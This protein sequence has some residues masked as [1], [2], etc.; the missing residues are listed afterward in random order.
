MLDESAYDYNLQNGEYRIVVERK[1]GVAIGP[2]I[3]GI[4]IDG[5]A[6]RTIY[7]SSSSAR[8]LDSDSLVFYFQ[9]EPISSIY[10]ANGYPTPNRQPTFNWSRLVGK[11]WAAVSY[12]FQLD[13]NYDFRSPIFD[14]TDLTSPQYH[15]S[16][17]L[18]AD[19]VY[20]WR[21]RPVTG[22]IPGDYS[23]TFA[24]YLLNNLCGDASSDAIVDISDVVYLIAYIFSGGS[25]PSPLLAGDASCDSMV[26]ISDV[27]YLIAYI[28][29]GGLA[30]CAV[31]K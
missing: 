6:S 10:P 22:G 1:S 18:E 5:T 27:V 11:E 12:D 28:F 9:V 25:A 3:L 15:I 16:H 4:R 7:A 30:P 14:I 29:S 8:N 24:A 31:C 2:S 20:Y 19:S 13:R 17:S 21:I 23:R 26:D